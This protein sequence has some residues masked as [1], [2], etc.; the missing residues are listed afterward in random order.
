M[1]E[2]VPDI[3]PD[4]TGACE[5]LGT[6]SVFGVNRKNESKKPWL[7]KVQDTKPGSVTLVVLSPPDASIGKYS[8]SV[9][10]SSNPKALSAGN[11]VLLFNPWCEKDSVYMAKEEEKKEYVMNEQGM[12]YRGS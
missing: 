8:L 7:A 1:P 4:G 5:D 11:F 3:I 2:Q 9:K 12:L 10:T 6:K